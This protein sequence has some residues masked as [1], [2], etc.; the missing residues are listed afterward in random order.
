MFDLTGKVALVTGAGRHVGLEISHVLANAGAT[1][2][3]NDINKDLATTAAATMSTKDSIAVVADICDQNQVNDMVKQ[4]VTQFGRI[5]ILVNN[6]GIPAKDGVFSKSF[7]ETD[8]TDWDAFFNLNLY[9]TMF[10]IQAVLPSMIEHNHGRII[11][12]VS[13]AARHGMSKMAAYAAS[14]A[15]IIALS[16]SIAVEYGR[17]AVTSNCVSLGT[18]PSKN[19]NEELRSKLARSYPTGRTGTPQDI[20]PAVLWLASPEASWVTGQ[21]IPVN[22]GYL[23]I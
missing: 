21:T 10:C 6:A 23:T 7:L 2:V 17:S 18:I 20:A 3:I 5:D 22:G 13:D 16:R 4:V 15:G 1:L 11:S 14:K 12:I 9:G 19:T 8:K